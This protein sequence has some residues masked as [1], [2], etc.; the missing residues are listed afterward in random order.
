MPIAPTISGSI[1]IFILMDM[2]E[3]RGTSPMLSMLPMLN[4][5]TEGLVTLTPSGSDGMV[6]PTTWVR[7][8]AKM[9]TAEDDGCRKTLEHYEGVKR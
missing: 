2:R 1:L 5:R 6:R 9:M 4:I 3:L 7:N 8:N